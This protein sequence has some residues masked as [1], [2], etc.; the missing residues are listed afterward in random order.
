MYTCDKDNTLGPLQLIDRDKNSPGVV[1][2]TLRGRPS[3]LQREKHTHGPHRDLHPAAP[4]LRF[5]KT[6]VVVEVAVGSRKEGQAGQRVERKGGS[7]G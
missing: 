6:A 2:V 3:E 1:G 5:G 4:L 7:A